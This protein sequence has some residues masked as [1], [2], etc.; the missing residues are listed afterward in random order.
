MHGCRRCTD[1]REPCG[2][3]RSRRWRAYGRICRRLEER[4][5]TAVGVTVGLEP[6]DAGRSFLLARRA[7]DWAG[8]C[9]RAGASAMR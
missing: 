2:V 9:G 7:A 3:R 8:A 6:V 1:E 4:Y 5:S